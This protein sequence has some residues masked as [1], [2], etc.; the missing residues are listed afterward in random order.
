[1]DSAT[2]VLLLDILQLIVKI[3]LLSLPLA[4]YQIYAYHQQKIK[5]LRGLKR[6]RLAWIFYVLLNT[7]TATALFLISHLP[8][9]FDPE[10]G[11]T[12]P[13]FMRLTS[14]SFFATLHWVSIVFTIKTFKIMP[15]NRIRFTNRTLGPSPSPSKESN[16]P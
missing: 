9:S 11:N 6:H 14:T 3:F 15:K 1:M 4:I 13:L 2:L 5:P 16:K 10:I 8:L 7:A 12:S